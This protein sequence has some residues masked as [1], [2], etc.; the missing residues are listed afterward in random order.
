MRV[1]QCTWKLQT[2]YSS[3]SPSEFD[4]NLKS[5]NILRDYLNPKC[6]FGWFFF[7]E[8]FSMQISGFPL[9]ETELSKEQLLY[10]EG[11]VNP[12]GLA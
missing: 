7:F 8:L 6:S 12:Y 3:P 5:L 1:L 11:R 9:Q 10:Y 2:Q 4:Q